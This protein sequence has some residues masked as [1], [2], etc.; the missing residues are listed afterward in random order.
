ME[1]PPPTPQTPHITD[2]PP[3]WY[4]N[5]MDGWGAWPLR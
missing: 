3:A 5:V 1:D 4:E 2:P